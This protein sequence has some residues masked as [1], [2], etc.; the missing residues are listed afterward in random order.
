MFQFWNKHL[1]PAANLRATKTKT[2]KPEE[3]VITVFFAVKYLAA[4]EEWSGA[5]D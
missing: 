2:L 5:D 4:A 3:G 1:K